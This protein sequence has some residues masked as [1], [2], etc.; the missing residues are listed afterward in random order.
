M[1]KRIRVK[2]DR[3]ISLSGILGPVIL[4]MGMLL[5]ALAYVGVEGQR[6][7]LANHFVSE[8]GELGVSEGAAVFNWGLIIGGIFTTIFMGYLAFQVK[9][10]LRYPLGLISTY[11]TVNGA[12]VGVY[13]MNFIEPHIRV[14]MSFFNL[15]LIVTFLYSLFFLFSRKHPFPRWVA[16]PGFI[17][18]AAFAWFLYFPAD[19]VDSGFDDGMAGFLTNRPDFIPLALLEWIIILGILIWVLILGVYLFMIRESTH[20]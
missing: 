14:A 11:A 2:F 10:W 16:V 19:T 4:G 1:G 17:N 20:K 12:L 9:H 18:A 7:N 3:L 13:P 15:G 5:A 8:L 6:Y